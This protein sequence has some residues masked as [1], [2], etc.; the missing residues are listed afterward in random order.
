MLTEDRLWG[1]MADYNERF[2]D[3]GYED[4]QDQQFKREKRE[5]DAQDCEDLIC[6]CCI[7]SKYYGSY[8]FEKP[9]NAEDHV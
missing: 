9:Y 8:G 1:Y 5:A 2:T 7:E 3:Y 4:D 6:S